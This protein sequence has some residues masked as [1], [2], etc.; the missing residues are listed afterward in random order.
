MRL[1]LSLSLA[2]SAAAPFGFASLPNLATYQDAT[3]GAS[4]TESGGLA[5]AWADRSGKGN[6]LVQA[7]AARRPLL[8]PNAINGLPALQGR[9][10][11]TNASQL[12][13]A[14]SAAL[15]LP[16]FHAFT[17]AKRVADTGLNEML[18]GKYEAGTNR[19]EWYQLLSADQARATASPDGTATGLAAAQVAAALALNVPFI[20]ESFYDGTVLGTALN[21]GTPVTAPLAT[22]YN[23]IAP[24]TLFSRE[25]SFTDP[26]AGCIA[27]FVLCSEVLSPA[28]RA[29]AI[30]RLKALGG[31]A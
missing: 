15:D 16:R 3:D 21:G 22:L 8:T 6:H 13:C 5:S 28:A 26:F 25:G 23:G 27:V 18:A 29:A 20:H 7:T 10:D 24:L 30:A 4:V 14:D 11:G 9:H 2:A 19:R 1:G 31:I 17:L 12:A